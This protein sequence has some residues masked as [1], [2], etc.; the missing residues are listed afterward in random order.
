ML[1]KVLRDAHASVCTGAGGVGWVGGHR[2][3]SAKISN[4]VSA[5]RNGE[6]HRGL[7][8]AYA[9]RTFATFC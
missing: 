5:C 7:T 6:T 9:R 3:S 1:R 4:E 2:Y 8:M